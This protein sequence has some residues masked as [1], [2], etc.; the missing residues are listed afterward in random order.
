MISAT[1]TFVRFVHF[2]FGSQYGE[3]LAQT[4][5][6]QQQILAE[7]DCDEQTFVRMKSSTWHNLQLQEERKSAICHIL[8][9][10]RWHEIEEDIEDSELPG[11]SFSS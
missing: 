3:Y 5:D 10:L 6:R 1:S 7:R 2:T 11:Y 9:L 8:A 4:S